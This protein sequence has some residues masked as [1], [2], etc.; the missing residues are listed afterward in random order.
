L[1]LFAL[2]R[3]EGLATTSA[4]TAFQILGPTLLS[5]PNA[6]DLHKR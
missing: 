5:I 1:A 6:D 4:S 2:F 3:L